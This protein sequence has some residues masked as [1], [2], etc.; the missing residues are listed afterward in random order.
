M[1][2]VTLFSLVALASPRVPGG[3]CASALFPVHR[4]IYGFNS[5]EESSMS[6]YMRIHQH[7]DLVATSPQLL[8]DLCF[9][10]DKSIGSRCFYFLNLP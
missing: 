5:S 3:F 1:T 10:S 6:G 4:N 8:R 9:L 7:Y 2:H